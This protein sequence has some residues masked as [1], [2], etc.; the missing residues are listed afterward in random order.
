MTIRVGVNGFG[1]IGRNFWRAVAAGD[2][3]IE[4]VAV[5]DLTDTKTLAHLLK[6]DT[7]LGTLQG[8][9]EVGDD[10]IRVGDKNIKVLA[11]RDPAQLPW[12]ELNV[13]VVVE[14]T[15]IFT[16][17]EDAKKH[18][19]AGAKK[20]IISA[21]AKGEDITIVMGVND[22][23]YDAASH[24]VISNA[25]CT[26]NCV[27]PMAKVLK[28]AFGI[29]QGFMTT[30]HAYTNDQ[31]ILDFPHKDLRRARAAAQNIIPTSTGAAKATALVI[32]ELA[33]KLDGMAM[34]VPV[35][36][37][38]ATDLVV[39]L[40]REVTKDEVNDAFKAAAEGPLKN[41]L[42]YTEDEIV[43]SDIVGTSPSCTFDA[44]MTMVSG[45]TVKIL[46]WY[47]NEWG[48]SNRLVDLAKLVGAGL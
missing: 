44:K 25:S 16:K 37:G 11:Q 6:Y 8:E 31:V 40:D 43:S 7:V 35:P 4:I 32:P 15:G 23:K 39:T 36:D 27:A 30:V 33:G 45:N 26:T 42:V 14:S 48:Y 12:G 20:V 34:R 29:Q 2:S 24:D 5:N 10:F 21:P 47:D 3:D 46:G 28:D 9:V 19:E 18:I 13:D 38:S 1:R 41:V 22:D 17:A